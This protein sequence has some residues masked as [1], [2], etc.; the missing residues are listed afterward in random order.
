MLSEQR[1]EMILKILEEKR[2][3]PTTGYMVD[4]IEETTACMQL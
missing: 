2:S 3:G 1:Y 4:L